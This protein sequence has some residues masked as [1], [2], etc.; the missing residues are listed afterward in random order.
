[1][2][3]LKSITPD[4][5]AEVSAALVSRGRPELVPNVEDGIAETCTYD[6]SVDAGYIYVARPAP[7]PHLENHAAPIAETIPFLE[8]GFNVDIDHAGYVFGIEL[9]DRVDIL[10]ALRAAN[11]LD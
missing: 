8:Y 4:F 2:T 10:E 1:M 9:L 3:A 5:V 6:E 7:S 11:A